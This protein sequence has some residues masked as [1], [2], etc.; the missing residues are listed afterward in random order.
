MSETRGHNTTVA[1]L[2]LLV[3]TAFGAFYFLDY[4]LPFAR[5][6]VVQTTVDD[7]FPG[8]PPDIRE[9][10]IKAKAASL[11]PGA[12]QR[13]LAFPDIPGNQWLRG[14]AHARCDMAFGP[15]VTGEDIA[16]HV[17]HGEFRDLDIAFSRDL[18]RHFS[19]T[20]FSEVIHADYS[21]I[22][23]D[24]RWEQITRGWLQLAPDSPYA[25]SARARYLLLAAIAARENKH[26]AEMSASQLHKMSAFAQEGIRLE[27]RALSAE[28]RLMPA[29][30]DQINLALIERDRALVAS[31][32][33]AAVALDPACKYV[34]DAA[35]LAVRPEWGG[36]YEQMFALAQHL[37]PQLARRP[38][39]A[40]TIAMPLQAKS[41]ELYE[42]KRYPESAEVLKPA[43]LHATDPDIFEG[44]AMALEE[45][46]GSAP[47]WPVIMYE[48]EATRFEIPSEW[49]TFQLGMKMDGGRV[50]RQWGMSILQTAIEHR[51][52][53]ATAHF[54]MAQDLLA[55]HR[56]AD[57]KKHY[58][59][60][61]DSPM[62][63]ADALMALYGMERDQNNDAAA[64]GYAD[65]LAKEYPKISA[66]SGIGKPK[67]PESGN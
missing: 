30:S 48:L 22:G 31:A 14:L 29:F 45:S 21:D 37:L 16:Y 11:I 42:A 63:R 1:L 39:L 43:A 52:N 19:N 8:A 20:D 47:F 51:P 26:F 60:I 34:N 25:Q 15:R 57:A 3:A 27:K 32:Y 7:R 9:F 53:D 41:A 28:P 44:I 65:A 33:Q 35:M 13:C 62:Y 58:L 55:E 56:P 40:D 50:D 66:D 17:R 36:S 10:M 54:L 46:D 59:A 18:A 61:L 23:G 4:G 64:Q 67:V 5:K 38:V 49:L 2:A 6:P 12:Y 24:D